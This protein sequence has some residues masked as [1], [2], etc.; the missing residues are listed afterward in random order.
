[1]YL[2]TGATGNVGREV[3]RALLADG[4]EVRALLRSNDRKKQDDLVLAG[5]VAVHGDL[6]DPGSLGP[7]LDGVDGVFLLPGYA[8]MPGVLAVAKRAGVGRVVQLSSRA[9]PL[10][11]L[12]AITQY[13]ATT[14]AAVLAAGLPWTIVRPSMFA[15]NALRWADQLRS[16]NTIKAPF[17]EVKNAVLHPADI[18]AVVAAALI[19]D[20]HIGVIHELSGPEAVTPADQVAVLAEV[21]GRNLRFE[22]QADDDARVEMEA[23]MPKKYVDAFFDF[24]VK[25]LL[26]EST[27]FPTVEKVTG[28]PPRTFRDWAAE[29]A[30]RFA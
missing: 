19:S 3:V 14:E 2:V 23:S 9:A 21:L 15:S 16:G 17:S 8:D 18:G 5:A 28:R 27:V 12:N 29:H 20:G 6:N 1:M 13:M 22:P 4:A 26:D 7:A 10:G 24:Y 11:D 30:H 25:G